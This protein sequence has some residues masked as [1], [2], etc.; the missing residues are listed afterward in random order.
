MTQDFEPDRLR[1]RKERPR[2]EELGLLVADRIAAAVRHRGIW[3]QKSSRT[4]EPH[5]LIKKLLAGRHTYD[6]MPDKV[7]ARCVV[8]YLDDLAVVEEIAKD[9]FDCFELDRKQNRLKADAVG[10]LSTHIQ[11]RLRADDPRVV[12]YGGLCVELQVRTL[13]QHLW[14]EM[15]HDT[16]YK[17]DEALAE[18]PLSFR[19]RLNLMAGLIEVADQEFNRLDK[20]IPRSVVVDAYAA[21]ERHY[22][23]LATARPDIDLSLRIIALMVPLYGSVP[24]TEIVRRL[25]A[26][27]DDHEEVLKEVYAHANPEDASVLL[28]QPEALMLFELLE[29]DPWAVR[30]QWST[31]FPEPELER[32]ANTFGIS[33]D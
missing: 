22:F 31:Q 20:E 10:Y 4:K 11:L 6:S 9:L 28:Y 16:V 24:A 21:M 17:N 8:R 5:S 12:D 15:S 27:F 30:R 25:D 18:I 26:F 33:F 14:S 29:A 19:R 7:G 3:C 32:V 2:Y 1:W 13:G 23:K